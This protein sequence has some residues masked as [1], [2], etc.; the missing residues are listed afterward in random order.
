[1]KYRLL[2]EIDLPDDATLDQVADAQV[3][4]ENEAKWQYIPTREEKLSQT[5][6]TNKCGSCIYFKPRPMLDAKCYG[7]CTNPKKRWRNKS[8]ALKQ[9]STL[10]CT[11]YERRT[12]DR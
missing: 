11:K 7:V 6:L 5:D 1:M 2:A 12:D 10:C 9:R 4:A 8:N 3:K